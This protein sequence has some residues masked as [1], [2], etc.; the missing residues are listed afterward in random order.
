MRAGRDL[1]FGLALDAGGGPAL[2]R[3]D[4]S[5]LASAAPGAYFE[6]RATVLAVQTDTPADW[7]AD[8]AVLVTV[9]RGAADARPAHE[10]WWAAFWA[11]SYVAVNMSAGSSRARYAGSDDLAPAGRAF[12]S[13]SSGAA[14]AA[15]PAGAGGFQLSRV[16]TLTRYVHAVQSR[17]TLWPIKFNGMAF[18][19][20]VNHGGGEPDF[21]DWGGSNWWQ[22][23]RMPYGAM[24]AAGDFDSHRVILE[25][26][27]NMARLLAP[28]TALYWNHSGL[29]T[30]E[31]HTLFGAYTPYFYGGPGCEAAR[32]AGFPVWLVANE[33]IRLDPGGDSGTGEW[34]LMAL[35]FFAHTGDAAYLPLAY[36]AAD[37]FMHHF[38]TNATSGRTV[39]W[40]T[41]VL[42]GYQCAF[43]GATGQFVD[44]CADDTPSISGMLTLF[45]KLLA[46]PPGVAT[47]AQ[48]AAWRAFSDARMPALPLTQDGSRIA[49]ARVL[50]SG[51]TGEGPELYP[52]H[53][54]RVFTAGRAAAGGRSLALAQAT[55][56]ASPFARQNEGWNYGL[57]AAALAGAT[58]L[59]AALLLARSASPPAAGYR[60]PGFA[61]HYQDFDPSADHFA[62]HNR[63]LLDMLLQS[64]DDGFT[65]TT[66]VLFPAW[67]CGWD[68]QAKLWAPLNTT[69]EIDYQAGALHSLVVTPP[70]RASAIRWAQCVGQ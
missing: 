68:V 22:N 36:G 19:A 16:Y 69:V 38:P 24:L 28:R 58:D 47:P 46:L 53:P 43:D 10:A 49:A 3:V 4:A 67:P 2:V 55:L 26:Y 6:L 27:A 60:W 51:S 44:C 50:N 15:A 42:E 64:G 66:V 31:T 7:L 32:P 48:A 65:N 37:Y 18:V 17:G 1:Q 13:A 52:M 11:R 45:E 12:V 20:A 35:D 54:H 39:L 61:P 25:Y 59:A 21:R 57:N 29:W 62:L 8:A 9:G 5:A 33:C 41:Q 34:A 23:T 40:P 70:S 63:C 56:A 14:A 30:P